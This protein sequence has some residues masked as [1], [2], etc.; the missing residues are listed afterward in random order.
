MFFSLGT[1][2]YE[3]MQKLVRYLISMTDSPVLEPSK[4]CSDWEG[5]Q[6]DMATC[7][8]AIERPN[9]GWQIWDAITEIKFMTRGHFSASDL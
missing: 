7:E 8:M 9:L 3:V 4:D 2:V 6:L 5:F 1:G